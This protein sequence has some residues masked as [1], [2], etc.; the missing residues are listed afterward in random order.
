M[1]VY[2][3]CEKCGETGELHRIGEAWRGIIEHTCDTPATRA[4]TPPYEKGRFHFTDLDRRGF[5]KRS[6]VF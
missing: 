4:V 2:A 1:R 6:D 3:V 5:R